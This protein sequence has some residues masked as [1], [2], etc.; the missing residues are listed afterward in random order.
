MGIGD[1]FRFHYI[2][3][4]RAVPVQ[5]LGGNGRPEIAVLR[6]AEV[7]VD[8]VTADI[9]E[10][11]FPR[12][13]ARCPANH[14]PQADAGVDAVHPVRARYLVQ[15]PR[16]RILGLDEKHGLERRFLVWRATESIRQLLVMSGGIQRDTDH[17]LIGY[18]LQP[19]AGQSQGIAVQADESLFIDRGLTQ[20]SIRVNPDFF[21]P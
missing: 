3:A 13:P 1:F 4:D 14:E 16:Q 19:G 2:W 9:I 11:L 20:C 5:A 15:V 10:P 17:R 18:G 8:G 6:Q 12:Y 21:H 7:I